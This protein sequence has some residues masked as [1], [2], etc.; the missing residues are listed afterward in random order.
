MS[1]FREFNGRAWLYLLAMFFVVSFVV[2]YGFRLISQLRGAGEPS[3]FA[4]VL[5]V[6]M[7]GFAAIILFG[8]W[9]EF[10]ADTARELAVP[11]R[12]IG[13]GC[14]LILAIVVCFAIG[15]LVL[16]WQIFRM[17]S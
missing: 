14:L 2:R 4:Q 13:Q 9:S 15:L 6:L 16:A 11:G 1:K 5:T 7:M 8:Y 17:R 10:R 12:A 3:M